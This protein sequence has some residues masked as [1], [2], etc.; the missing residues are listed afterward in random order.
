MNPIFLFRATYLN[1]YLVGEGM[2]G[3]VPGVI[4]LAQGVGGNPYCENVTYPNETTTEVTVVPEARFSV[5][6]F[7]S[8][9]CAMMILSSAA[10]VL[11]NN[12]PKFRHVD[13]VNILEIIVPFVST[14][15]NKCEILQNSWW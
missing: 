8:I 14:Y 10:F 6:V 11:M 1:S 4:A 2:S 3:L 9:L 5:E 15:H 7:F 13:Y 12:V